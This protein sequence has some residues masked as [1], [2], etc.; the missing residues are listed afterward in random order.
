[1]S[2]Q[3]TNTENKTAESLT[4]AEEINLKLSQL[5]GKEI[6]KVFEGNPSIVECRACTSFSAIYSTTEEEINCPLGIAD[7]LRREADCNLC[8]TWF[9]LWESL[10][11]PPRV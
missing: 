7:L 8:E 11:I 10:A 1:M 3:E 2:H 6:A 5:L 9:N 4:T